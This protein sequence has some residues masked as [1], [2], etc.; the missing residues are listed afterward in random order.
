MRRILILF[1][2]ATAVVM[3]AVAV[4]VLSTLPPRAAR[5]S[6]A[7][8]R[9]TLAVGAWHV[10]SSRSDGS[11]SVEEIAAAAAG[12]GLDF[13]ILTDHG[14]ATRAPDPPRYVH[15][16]LIIDAVEINTDS[17]H[18][19]AL[20]LDGPSAFP[21]AGDVRDVLDDIHRLGGWAVAAHPDS[22][23]QN[24]RWRGQL[25][26]VDGVEWLNVDSEWRGHAP[27][28]IAA[29]ALRSVVRGPESIASMFRAPSPGLARWD[30]MQ[31]TRPVVGL[32]AVDAHARLGADDSS[33]LWGRAASVKFPSYAALF[34]T[35]VQAVPLSGARSGSAATDARAIL[36]GLR[37]GRSYSIVRA[38]VDLFPSLEFSATAPQMER[39]GMG[40]HVPPGASGAIVAEIPGMQ[41]T[42]L[43]LLRDGRV[44]KSGQGRLAFDAP[45]TA[46]PYRVEAYLPGYRIPWLVTNS[47]YFDRENATPVPG[48]V[49]PSSVLQGLRVP[50]DSWRIEANATSRGSID[51]DTAGGVVVS[52]RLGDGAPAGQYVAFATDASGASA[53]D[54][55]AITATSATPMRLSLQVRV[56]GGRDGRRWRKSL[57][58]DRDPRTYVVS[59]GDMDPVER[60]SLLRPIVAKVQSVLLVIDT[61]NASPGASGV[62]NIRAVTLVTAPPP[63]GTGR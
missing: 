12:A 17:G 33:S 1:A 45:G 8:N 48:N 51:R 9:S 42:R 36:D 37:A 29:S 59:L 41:S 19:V 26:G 62:V 24:L 3:A 13:V 40:G 55:I 5:P 25:T 2:L 39:I 7:P 22:P 43:D 11:G 53:L 46:A 27:A 54:R 31:R 23:R 6:A 56:P 57:Y 15:D 47:I 30:A 14:D 4:F 49:A 50:Q 10:H 34:R 58:L 28:E 18:V 21:L 32:A 16:V 61:V 52:Y 38:F 63:G 44:V 35:V 20:N 60:G